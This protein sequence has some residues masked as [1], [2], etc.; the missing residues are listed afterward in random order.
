MHLEILEN[1]TKQS[2]ESHKIRR[3]TMECMENGYLHGYAKTT[4]CGDVQVV[5]SNK[6]LTSF[7]LS[8][9]VQKRNYA[10]KMYEK[11]GFTVVDENSFL[12]NSDISNYTGSSLYLDTKSINYTLPVKSMVFFNLNHNFCD[13]F[14]LS[15]INITI[16]LE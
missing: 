13:I 1:S 12:Y 10:V 9:S 16:Q 15:A 11:V 7:G 4:R 2:K 8:L 3:T 6:R 14:C 5:I